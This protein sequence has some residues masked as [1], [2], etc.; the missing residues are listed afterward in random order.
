MKDPKTMSVADL[1][2]NLADCRNEL[3]LLCGDYKTA[4]KGAC[5]GCRWKMEASDA[6]K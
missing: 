1:Q 5:D 6:Q 2:R 4:H 3:C